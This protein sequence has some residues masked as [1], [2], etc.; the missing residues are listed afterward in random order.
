MTPRKPVDRH[1]G[2]SDEGAMGRGHALAITIALAGCGA[3]TPWPGAA[4]RVDHAALPA[5]V[6]EGAEPGTAEDY[7]LCGAALAFN[8]M[9]QAPAEQATAPEFTAAIKGRL[10]VMT[11]TSPDPGLSFAIGEAVTE[12]DLED[13][14]NLVDRV[15]DCRARYGRYFS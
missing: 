1:H 9:A 11:L 4:G 15:P 13:R 2:K 8:A 7:G 12:L 6:A 3:D 10:L 14:R 5:L